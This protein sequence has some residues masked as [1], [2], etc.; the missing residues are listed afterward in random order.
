MKSRSTPGC[1]AATC[2]KTRN[3]ILRFPSTCV[4][5]DIGERCDVGYET[6]EPSRQSGQ[7]SREHEDENLV[8]VHAI[9]ERD[10]TLLVVADRMQDFAERRM[11]DAE[12]RRQNEPADSEDEVVH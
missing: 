6:F 11:H 7:R 8:V 2:W 12:D 10:G 5:I 3:L 4:P 9:A 1:S